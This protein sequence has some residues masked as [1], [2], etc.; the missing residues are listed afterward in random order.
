[1]PGSLPV[2]S[3]LE[4]T[5]LKTSATEMWVRQALSLNQV[6]SAPNEPIPHPCKMAVCSHAIR[7][8]SIMTDIRSTPLHGKMRYQ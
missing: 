1:M 6:D 3:C 2:R 4:A 7:I 5:L 8:F